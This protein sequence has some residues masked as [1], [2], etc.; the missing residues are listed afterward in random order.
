MGNLIALIRINLVTHFGLGIG[1]WQAGEFY[2]HYAWSKT[3]KCLP[4]GLPSR[5]LGFNLYLMRAARPL[6]KLA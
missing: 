2:P 6:W 3:F 5:M 4:I 1:P